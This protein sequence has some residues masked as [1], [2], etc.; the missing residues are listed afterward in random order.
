MS[1]KNIVYI[2]YE[3]V[4]S[5]SSQLFE[6]IVQSAIEQQESTLSNVDALEVKAEKN[7]AA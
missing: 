4:Y 5:L 1:L 7:L 3:K 6:G 2:D